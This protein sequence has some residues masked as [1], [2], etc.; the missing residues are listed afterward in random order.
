MAKN[1]KK[2]PAA[3]L[4]DTKFS[5]HSGV[6]VMPPMPA[7]LWPTFLVFFL[8]LIAY[9]F[10][11]AHS[12]T[13]EDSGVFI[14][15]AAS[16]G[17]PQPPG[18]P[19]YTLIAWLFTHLP[20]AT[21]AYRV[22][23][24]SGLC[25]AGSALFLYLSARRLF[26]GNWQVALIAALLFAFGDTV[27]SQAIVAEVYPLHILLFSCLFFIT[28][29][30]IEQPARKNFIWFGVVFGLA[31]ANHWPLLILAAPMFLAFA[32][33]RRR[34]ILRQSWVWAPIALIIAAGFYIFMMWRSQQNPAVSFLGPLQTWRDL[35]DYVA[36]SYYRGIEEKWN[37]R[38]IDKLLFFADAVYAA[39]WREWYLAGTIFVAGGLYQA[40]K[41]FSRAQLLGLAFAFLSTTFILQITINF[42]FNDLNQNVMKVFHL[43]PLFATAIIMGCGL[44]FLQKK[45]GVARPLYA[46][47]VAVVIVMIANYIKNDLHDDT[48]AEGYSRFV[49]D[50][51]PVREKSQA[52]IAGTDAD[53]GPLAYIRVAL[54]ERQD[55][56]LYT[57][58]GVFFRERIFD[59]FI[60][61]SKVRYEKT[62]QFI[63]Q[64][65]IVYSTKSMDI[66]EA[67]K[68]LPFSLDY[69][70]LFYEISAQS[71]APLMF[72]PETTAKAVKLLDD[73]TAR[74]HSANWSYHRETL[75]S[76]LCNFVVLRGV[77]HPA[78]KKSRA[79]QQVWARH[80]TKNKRFA[81]ADAIYRSLIESGRWMINAERHL[82]RYHQLINRMEWINTEPGNL[83]EKKAKVLAAV[84]YVKPGLFEY[85]QCGNSLFTVID[86]LRSQ[87]NLPGDVID[88]LAFFYKC[89]KKEQRKDNI[90]NGID[91]SAAKGSK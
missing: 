75:A 44:L 86:S 47:S 50:A 27:W 90:A 68:D 70:G 84:D 82:L 76:R 42:E 17:L 85:Q 32:W 54:N 2:A 40:K 1:N 7:P 14:G 15:A 65:G 37:S 62:E 29:K 58:S 39:F 8:P 80:L 22:H 61:K 5:A 73:Y 6:D 11:A 78:Y 63:K 16:L 46:A 71:R 23:I 21:V 67:A 34:E 79:C 18:Y 69:N 52:V 91:P 60:M 77:E 49:L 36:R 3:K 25:V 31:L 45:F 51:I 53:V 12:V 4:Q 48:L 33:P 72:G 55:L 64:E 13:F 87:V 66:F 19:L 56:R 89:K 30:I 57:Q 41:Y 59:P 10:S 35:Y 83:E 28:L 88:G 74:P 81:E 38:F 26:A 43:V 9:L 20:F 24:F